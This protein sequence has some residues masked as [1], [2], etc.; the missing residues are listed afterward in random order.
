MGHF[1]CQNSG[2]D[3]MKKRSLQNV[4]LI[5]SPNYL[6]GKAKFRSGPGLHL[7]GFSGVI[8]DMG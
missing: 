7:V 1:S 8:Q 3:Q 4:V 2:G 5:L 6:G